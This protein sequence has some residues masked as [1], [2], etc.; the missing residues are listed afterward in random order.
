[1]EWV[2]QGC[3]RGPKE[4][5]GMAIAAQVSTQF[6]RTKSIV[7]C[8]SGLGGVSKQKAFWKSWDSGV[9]NF[10]WKTPNEKVQEQDNKCER[11]KSWK[12]YRKQ[13]EQVE[14]SKKGLEQEDWWVGIHNSLLWSIGCWGLVCLVSL[15]DGDQDR[16]KT[17][18]GTHDHAPSTGMV[19]PGVYIWHQLGQPD[20]FS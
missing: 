11:A 6:R 9:G 15:K 7:D 19:G 12:L 5:V 8:C 2:D 14:S 13:R 1:M 10:R 16:H 17:A 4:S 20:F 3:K 18:F